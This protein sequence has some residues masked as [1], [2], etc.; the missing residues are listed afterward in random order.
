MTR[1]CIL[2]RS[3]NYF[4]TREIEKFLERRGAV[5]AY[6]QTRD[7]R[8]L[9]ES[10]GVDISYEGKSIK[11]VNAVIPRIGRSLTNFG[12]TII[13]HFE[14]LGVPTTLSS[15][16]LM[17]ARDKFR[18]LQ[19]LSTAGIPI[20]PTWLVASRI[21]HEFVT[22]ELPFPVVIKLLSGTQGIGVIRVQSAIDAI[23]IVDALD[24]LDQRVCIQKYLENPGEDIR[25]FIV[26]GGVV[27]AMKRIAPPNDWRANIHAGGK[28]V[29]YELTSEEE[30]IV[31]KAA[32]ALDVGVA[33]VDMIQTD[34]GTY[35]IE[36][37]VSPGF[38]GLLS[39]TGVNAA[40]A[41]AD[42]AMRIAKR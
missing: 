20:P 5:P 17:N 18:T 33:G 26:D 11:G 27:A 1:I 7:V 22:E 35:V 9:A 14:I 40:E 8:L 25:A 12:Y 15:R 19:D 30:E 6:V 24:E 16:G 21:R 37:N 39:A 41:I 34:E 10:D 4:S 31:I 28:G 36:V 42:Y 2:S 23:S 3:R 38:E 29:T 32:R 13:R